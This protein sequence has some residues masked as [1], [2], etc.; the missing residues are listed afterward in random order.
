MSCDGCTR[1][2]LLQTLALGTAGVIAVGCGN[3]HEAPDA[4]VTDSGTDA[5]SGPVTMCGANLCIDISMVPALQATNGFMVFPITTPRDKIMV[6]RQ[7]T[8]TF[9]TLSAICTHAGCTVGF[10]SSLQKFLCPCHGSQFAMDGT[11]T[12]SPAARP[13]KKYTNTF[14]AGTQILTIMLA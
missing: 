5:P 11:V 3:D 4:G 10:A 14:D 7:D 8:A 12:R 6:V 1:R 13:L 9:D 2:S